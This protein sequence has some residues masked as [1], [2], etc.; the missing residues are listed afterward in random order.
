MCR[1]ALVANVLYTLAQANKL[2]T[3]R[4]RFLK[5]GWYSDLF[6]CMLSSSSIVFSSVPSPPC[7]WPN[8]SIFLLVAAMWGIESARY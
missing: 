1:Y 4:V 3:M 7:H 8:I 6:Y 2:P 5:F